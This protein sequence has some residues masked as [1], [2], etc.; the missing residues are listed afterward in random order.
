MQCRLYV[1]LLAAC[2]KYVTSS[3]VHVYKSA[4]IYIYSMEESV[5]YPIR[6]YIYLSSA[7]CM[8]SFC[9]HHTIQ[10]ISLW[11]VLSWP[12]S[13]D[14]WFTVCP[15]WL[16]CIYLSIHVIMILYCSCTVKIYIIIFISFHFACSTHMHSLT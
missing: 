14:V 9:L 3:L 4:P 2:Y 7:P 8:E 10:L 12:C 6:C 16:C 11:C 5:T 15:C 13:V 1:D